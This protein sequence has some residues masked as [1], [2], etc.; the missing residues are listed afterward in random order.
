MDQSRFQVCNIGRLPAHKTYKTERSHGKIYKHVIYCVPTFANPSGKTMPRARREALVRLARRYDALVI[1]DDVYDFLSWG[2]SQD[3]GSVS[4]PPAR[5]VDIDRVLDDGPQDRFGNVVSNGSFSKLIGPG[6][7]V[8]WAEGMPD[9]IYGLSEAYVFTLLQLILALRGASWT[10]N[11]TTVAPRDLAV[12]HRS[13]CRR[14]SM[15]YWKITSC[16]STSVGF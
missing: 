13:S 8:G 4:G 15:S 12:L 5:L 1:T 7:R 6:C 10:D 2:T 14:L 16:P 9:F 11:S 3:P